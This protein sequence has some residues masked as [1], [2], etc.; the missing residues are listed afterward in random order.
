MKHLVLIVSVCAISGAAI[1]G[2]SASGPIAAVGGDAD[3]A[4]QYDSDSGKGNPQTPDAANL[5]A[6]ASVVQVVN[7]ATGLGDVRICFTPDDTMNPAWPS[8]TN[9]PQ[10]NYP[11]LELGGVVELPN[12]ELLDGKML[13]QAFVIPADQLGQAEFGRKPYTCNE[14]AMNGLFNKIPVAPI[15]LDTFGPRIVAL[16]GCPKNVG[17]AARCGA[18]FDLQNG[19]LHFES[20]YIGALVPP[21]AN[22]I[23][24]LALNLS[25]SVEANVNG[26]MATARIGSLADPCKGTTAIST[27]AFKVGVIA[28]TATDVTQPT[29]FDGE[30]FAACPI[31]GAPLVVRS[32]AQL[33]AATAPES[34]PASHFKG[35]S[36]FVL[37]IVGDMT[38]ATGHEALHALAIRFESKN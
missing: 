30:G 33:Q 8:G 37:T 18:N 35:R 21:Q 3:G 14:L 24:M 16:V 15:K 12:P 34:L 32:Y 31:S 17:T 29:A 1:L 9:I 28:P 22:Q 20:V 7:A 38:V 4:G 5:D 25:P 13:D 10:T 26:T 23:G 27:S 2:C 19:N 36:D 11:G 6:L